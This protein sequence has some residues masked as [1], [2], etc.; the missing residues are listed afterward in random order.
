MKNNKPVSAP[1]LP[2][3]KAMDVTDPRRKLTKTEVKAMTKEQRQARQAALRTARGPARTRF[4]RLTFRLFKSC[5]KFAVVFANEPAIRETFSECEDS[6]H[7]LAGKIA[8][9][10]AEWAPAK[11]ISAKRAAISPNALIEIRPE[12]SKMYEDILGETPELTVVRVIGKRI[13]ALTQDGTKLFLPLNHVRA[14]VK[15]A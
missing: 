6:L 7:A 4:V 3:L 9:L 2:N 15:E 5:E 8:E 13:V 1:K 12:K 11:K 14:A 10:P